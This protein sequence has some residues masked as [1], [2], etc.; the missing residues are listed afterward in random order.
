MNE[1]VDIYLKSLLIAIILELLVTL[2][3]L[4]FAAAGKLKSSSNAKTYLLDMVLINVLTSPLFA[5]AILA[6]T[7]ML[8]VRNL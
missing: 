3:G 8:R 5:F 2:V 7:F 6:I 4:P 1:L